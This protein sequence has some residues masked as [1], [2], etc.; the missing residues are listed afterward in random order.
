MTFA[1]AAGDGRIWRLIALATMNALAVSV[2]SFYFSTVVLD[3]FPTLDPVEI[4]L[5]KAVCGIVTLLAIV[6]V[7][8]SSDR[9]G[10]RRWHIVGAAFAAAVGFG[11]S[12][13][14]RRPDR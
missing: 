11:L 9:T 1:Q 10:E 3:R 8:V 14:E 12:M 2:L 5:L 7:G 6:A 13:H 4:G